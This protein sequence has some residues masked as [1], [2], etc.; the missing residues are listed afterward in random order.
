MN[1][2]CCRCSFVPQVLHERE[3]YQEK[4]HYV[5]DNGSVVNGLCSMSRVCELAR[6]AWRP[7][8]LSLC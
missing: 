1:W 7:L 4:A 6:M 5:S 2:Q 8:R 3:P